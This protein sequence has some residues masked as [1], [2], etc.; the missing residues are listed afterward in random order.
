[1]PTKL[2]S[3][4]SSLTSQHVNEVAFPLAI[5]LLVL[6]ALAGTGVAVLGG[7][8]WRRTETGDFRPTY[9]NWYIERASDEP[10]EQFAERSVERARQ[11]IGRS[12]RTG[13]YVTL[14]CRALR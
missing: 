11:E 4:G 13:N 2:R 9:E 10:G 3:S 14:T 12:Q 6:E 7:D 1:V 5:A 8:F